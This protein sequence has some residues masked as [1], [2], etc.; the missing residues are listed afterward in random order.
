METYGKYELLERISSG[1]R[2]EVFLGRQANTKSAPRALVIKRLKP[3]AADDEAYHRAVRRAAEASASL[4]HPCIALIEGFGSIE[5]QPFV[6]RRYVPGKDLRTLLRRHAVQ[7]RQFPHPLAVHLVGSLC[8]VLSYAHE[9]TPHG[10]LTPSDVLID[11]DGN[12][13]LLNFGM[14]S[15]WARLA[16]GGVTIPKDKARFLAPEQVEEGTL[17]RRADLFAL[18]LILYE[19]LT[20]TPA[21]PDGLTPAALRKLRTEGPPPSPSSVRSAI[22]AELDAVTLKALE[23]GPDRRYQTPAELAEALAPFEHG[24]REDLALLMKRIF[25]N[26]ALLEKQREELVATGRTTLPPE[27]PEDVDEDEQEL[28]KK[29]PAPSEKPASAAQWIGLIAVALL[30]LTVYLLLKERPAS[31]VPAATRDFSAVVRPE[32]A[33]DV[34]NGDMAPDGRYDMAPDAGG[35]PNPKTRSLGP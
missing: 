18:G 19:L 30:G 1:E 12:I 17:D 22:P 34:R 11:F 2:N 10:C 32:P 7:R 31:E 29:P 16:S 25:G 20:G 4:E 26:E 28:K 8:E 13:R 15:Y 9:E 6:A 5:E 33:S 3:Q 35:D 21:L 27:D 24:S 14:G 23:L